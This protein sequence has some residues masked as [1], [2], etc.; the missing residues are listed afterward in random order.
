MQDKKLYGQEIQLKMLMKEKLISIM[1]EA[2]KLQK[3]NFNKVH[4]Y[5][6]KESISSIVTETD[7]LCERFILDS[8]SSD[9]PLH[10]IL[11]EETGFIY[12]KSK[13]TWIV[14]PLDGTSNFAAGIPWFGVLIAI[15]ENN[16]PVMAGAYIPLEKKLFFAEA[17]KGAFLNKK[18]LRIKESSLKNV[19]FAFSTDYSDDKESI[20]NALKIFR[21][22]IQNTR[23]IRSTNSLVDFMMVAE[24]K[25]G[26]V[27]NMYTRIWDIAAPWLIIKEAG[28]D[29]KLLDFCDVSFEINKDETDKN[30]PVFTGSAS[31]MNEFEKGLKL[32]K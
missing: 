14:D 3:Q 24:G 28:G 30:Y 1:E 23:N 12:K 5:K 7:I 22:L 16:A 9:F 15:L 2:G 4:R 25:L 17:G 18:R 13:F 26:G 10:N 32:I 21:F 20:E 19:L 31:I 8:I 6:Q 11:S 27:V 29:L